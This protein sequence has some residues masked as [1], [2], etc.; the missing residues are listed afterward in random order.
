MTFTANIARKHAEAARNHAVAVARDTR[1]GLSAR[2]DLCDVREVCECVAI[3]KAFCRE[4]QIRLDAKDAPVFAPVEPCAD[5]NENLEMSF[6]LTFV[7]YPKESVCDC[8]L[9][10]RRELWCEDCAS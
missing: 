4:E 9:V 5:L 10:M 3:W 2:Y 6:E 8:R 7:G 1:C